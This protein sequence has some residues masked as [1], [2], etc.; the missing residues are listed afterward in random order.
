MT[1][2]VPYCSLPLYQSNV[3]YEYGPDSFVHAGVPAGETIELSWNESTIYPG[4]SRTFWVHVPA[5]YEPT[6]PAALMVF[7]DGQCYLDPKG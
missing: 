1:T 7:R 5:L 2:Q 4:T 3:R 6:Q